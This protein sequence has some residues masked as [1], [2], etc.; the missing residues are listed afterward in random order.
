MDKRATSRM[1][2]KFGKYS[3]RTTATNL[4][5]R[6]VVQLKIL[7]D[8]EGLTEAAALRYIV[9]DWLWIWRRNSFE[10]D[11]MT[12]RIRAVY[13]Q[14]VIKEVDPLREKVNL[15]LALVKDMKTA[16]NHKQPSVNQGE[17]QETN[18][19]WSAEKS[20][21]RVADICLSQSE[22]ADLLAGLSKKLAS[23]LESMMVRQ[24][25]TEHLISRLFS[26]ECAT[27]R[28]IID[29]L[30]EDRLRQQG[31]QPHKLA[32]VIDGICEP[33]ANKGDHALAEIEDELAVPEELRLTRWSE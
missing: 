31:V 1:K 17:T 21:Q 18:K 4:Y 27:Q 26:L 23:K 22:Q 16:L 9:H 6:D 10:N 30:V 33:F 29:N 28:F 20:P 24:I 7:C 25:V 3:S 2:K 15:L 32:E 12:A 13:S 11:E 8:E 19:N 14:I 5:E